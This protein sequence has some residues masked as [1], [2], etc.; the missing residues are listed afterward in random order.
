M[1]RKDS[2]GKSHGGIEIFF[3]NNSNKKDTDVRE[4]QKLQ[5]TAKDFG[6]YTPMQLASKLEEVN[7][8]ITKGN[9]RDAVVALETCILRLR[10]KL[11]DDKKDGVSETSGLAYD[12]RNAILS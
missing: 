12:V 3:G 1:H 10:G 11:G 2:N 7:E 5:Y 4:S 6:D 8:S 9:T